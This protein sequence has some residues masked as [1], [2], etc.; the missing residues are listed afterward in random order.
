[1]S[2]IAPLTPEEA[3]AIEAGEPLYVEKVVV[4]GTYKNGVQFI[5]EY[6]AGIQLMEDEGVMLS[7]RMTYPDP[8][9][10]QF[11]PHTH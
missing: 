4:H 8:I 7:Y 11:D 9:E 1:M 5:R 3:A 6:P 10:E 2:L